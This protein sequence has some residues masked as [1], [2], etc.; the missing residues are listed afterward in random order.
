MPFVDRTERLVLQKQQK[1]ETANGRARDRGEVALLREHAII[2]RQIFEAHLEK[3]DR[4]IRKTQQA[5][6]IKNAQS[7]LRSRN[8]KASIKDSENKIR[9]I[10]YTEAA[11]HP[12]QSFT[13][14]QRR[15]RHPATK[16][17]PIQETEKHV[18]VQV[19][20]SSSEEMSI[21]SDS[22]NVDDVSHTEFT[23]EAT[24]RTVEDLNPPLHTKTVLDAETQTQQ[25]PELEPREDIKQSSISISSK[26]DKDSVE[27]IST[28]PTEG[29]AILQSLLDFTETES[30]ISSTILEQF[31]NNQTSSFCSDDVPS[32]ASNDVG[33]SSYE[34]SLSEAL[35]ME[36]D[37]FM[38]RYL[39]PP[40]DS[41][42]LT[43]EQ[44]SLGNM[45]YL[46]E[47]SEYSDL[48]M[49]PEE[50]PAESSESQDSKLSTG[51]GDVN[52][53][54]NHGCRVKT[55]VKELDKMSEDS[56]YL[57]TSLSELLASSTTTTLQQDQGL[58]LSQRPDS[59]T[60]N[61]LSVCSNSVQE[62]SKNSDSGYSLLLETIR[63]DDAELVSL[64]SS[65]SLESEDYDSMSEPLSE[66]TH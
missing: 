10:L 49:I 31:P 37:V 29:N 18:G 39:Q 51:F 36:T 42:S 16:R 66:A 22:R 11:A 25:T 44:S 55:L 40:P 23:P 35:S 6:H 9:K 53:D 3:E 14:P 8:N 41:L 58:I 2:Q 59:S 50:S 13:L 24:V 4:S 45:S 61:C 33:R 65:L 60:V 63:E 52:T 54:R 28:T 64:T 7:A 21:E 48:S 38:Q 1:Q 5:Q 57:L 27:S 32:S 20:L 26:E 62:N 56:V 12:K 34:D 17:H 30:N 43:S 15:P 47:D 46:L 19:D